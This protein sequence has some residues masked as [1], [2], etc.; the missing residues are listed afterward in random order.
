[1]NCLDCERYL[2]AALDSLKSQSWQDFEII[3]WDNGSKD[4]SAAIAQDFGPQLRYFHAD[5]TVPLGSAR[6][7]AI[8]QA[9]G[10]YIAFLDCDDIWRPLKLEKQIALLESN[11]ALGLV[12]TDTVI[13]NDRKQLYRLFTHA[14][15][16]RG[17]VFSELMLRQWVSMSSAVLRM[18]ALDSIADPE[19]GKWFDESLNLCEEADVFYRIAHDWQCDYVDE[20]LTVWRVHGHNTTIHKFGRFADET[21]AIL[22]KHRKLYQGYDSA[23][24]EIVEALQTRADFQ[25]AVSLW[26]KGEGRIARRI[27]R[28]HKHKNVKY[29]LF[30]WVSFLPGAMF[31]TVAQMYF[32]LPAWLRG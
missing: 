4:D 11:P 5:E 19:T 24:P 28:P 30:W 27:I 10:E 21:C 8:A 26:Q 23:Y 18:R 16:A 7:L 12:C 25:R 2:P 6:N 31:E 9:K 15:P 3:F 20:P 1:M 29:R 22:A 13:A 32:S 14:E 17:T